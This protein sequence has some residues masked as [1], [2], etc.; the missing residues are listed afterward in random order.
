MKPALTICLAAICIFACA[1]KSRSAAQINP[2]IQY[3]YMLNTRMPSSRLRAS[4]VAP[5]ASMRVART[6]KFSMPAATMNLPINAKTSMRGTKNNKWLL[7]LK[8]QQ[9][10][11]K[12]SDDNDDNDPI[13]YYYYGGAVP[14]CGYV[15]SGMVPACSS[16]Y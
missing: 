16:S 9:S 2:A 15:G 6:A 1:A 8:A 12:G 10:N 5:S 3:K 4:A 7:L 14:N 13:P 11:G